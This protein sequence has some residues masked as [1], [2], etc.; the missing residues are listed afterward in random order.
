MALIARIIGLSLLTAGLGAEI[1]FA[2]FGRYA[3]Y[4]IPCILLACTGGII[5]AVAGAAREIVT[6]LRPSAPA[7]ATTDSRP[8]ALATA[9]AR[10]AVT[11]PVV[12]TI[13][14]IFACLFVR[15]QRLSS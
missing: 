6:A 1:G 4:A 12:L 13:L 9:R 7:P 8:S 11:L 3:D 14:V 15:F 10:L 2:F 5:G